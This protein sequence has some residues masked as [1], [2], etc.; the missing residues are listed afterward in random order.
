MHPKKPSI[1]ASTSDGILETGHKLDLSCETESKGQNI[2]YTFYNGTKELAN[3]GARNDTITITAGQ[4]ASVETYSCQVEINGVK[5]DNSTTQK[6]R[7]IGKI[8]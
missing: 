6:I 3:N 4:I 8:F 7:I 5:S 1:T 2:T